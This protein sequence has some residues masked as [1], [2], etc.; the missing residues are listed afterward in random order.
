MV[1]SLGE[2]RTTALLP[3]PF[4]LPSILGWHIQPKGSFSP[5]Q[6]QLCPAPSLLHGGC[7][8]QGVQAKESPAFTL[9]CLTEVSVTT[10]GH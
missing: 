1:R 6:A 4:L 8:G 2:L 7:P 5:R 10:P 3:Q 9:I